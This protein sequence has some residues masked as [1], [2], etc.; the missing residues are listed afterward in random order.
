MNFEDLKAILSRPS[1][2][3]KGYIPGS[4]SWKKMTNASVKDWLNFVKSRKKEGEHFGKLYEKTKEAISNKNEPSKTDSCEYCNKTGTSKEMEEDGY[5]G[6]I[7]K[8][9]KND[10][11][12]QK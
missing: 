5:H 7:V 3:S 10:T 8:I 4:G 2:A 9:K 12:K 6:S 1:F 11:N